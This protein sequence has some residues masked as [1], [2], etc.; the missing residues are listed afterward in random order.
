MDD[1]GEAHLIALACSPPPE[2]HDHWTLRLLAGKVVELGL[3]PSM[4]HEGINVTKTHTFNVTLPL[5][6]VNRRKRRKAKA[7]RPAR[8][9]TPKEQKAPTKRLTT[10]R[11]ATSTSVTPRTPEEKRDARRQYD[12]IRNKRPD[13]KELHRRKAGEKRTLAKELDLCRDCY[14][15]PKPNQTRCEGCA[16]RHR[17]Y[18]RQ[19]RERANQQ[20]EQGSGQ[21]KIF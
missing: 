7:P 5:P 6:K 2:G 3:T 10:R 15:M 19:A 21:T 14:G 9:Q 12:R 20:R 1:R 11:K 18:R 16:E 4:S 17:Q 13:R 8:T